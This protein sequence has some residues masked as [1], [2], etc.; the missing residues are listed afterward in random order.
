MS[1]GT[2]CT[3]PERKAPIAARRWRVIQRRCN[4]SAFNGYHYTPSE[5]SSVTCIACGR[6]W[7]TK[8]GYAYNLPDYD[9]AEWKAA[10]AERGGRLLAA[11]ENWT[12]NNPKRE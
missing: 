2:G 9:E 6:A 10:I 11:D 7:R 12:T 3:C 4:H 1:G 5:W 8:A